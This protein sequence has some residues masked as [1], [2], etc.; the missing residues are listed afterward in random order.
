[1]NCTFIKEVDFF[2]TFIQKKYWIKNTEGLSFTAA[3]NTYGKMKEKNTKYKTNHIIS[4]L[5]SSVDVL[6]KTNLMA[7]KI[8]QS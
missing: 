4:K 7:A 2:W 6:F 8:R 3:Q 1:M 5:L